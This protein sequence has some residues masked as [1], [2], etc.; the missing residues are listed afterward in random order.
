M[1][2][3]CV[4][5][6]VLTSTF[7]VIGAVVVAVAGGGCGAAVVVLAALVVVS[8]ARAL[9]AEV[10]ERV[11]DTALRAPV[12]AAA[13]GERAA[14][15]ADGAEAEVVLGEQLLAARRDGRTRLVVVFATV[16][17]SGCGSGGGI[18]T[19]AVKVRAD[20]ALEAVAVGAEA[21]GGAGRVARGDADELG[22]EC[23]EVAHSACVRAMSDGTEHSDDSTRD[24]QAEAPLPTERERTAPAPA[25]AEAEKKEGAEEAKEEE[26]SETKPK[27]VTLAPQTEVCEPRTYTH[28]R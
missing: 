19:P 5:V 22:D 10:P 12:R 25:P 23:R 6:G 18:L 13:E 2:K 4:C 28:T 16:W 11:K 14:R 7:V 27:M 21:G 8:A 17:C 15:G 9:L 3:G 1:R 20:G 26:E 24:A